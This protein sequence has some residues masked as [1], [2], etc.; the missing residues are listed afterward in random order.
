[1]WVLP[2]VLYLGYLTGFVHVDIEE[3]DP[4]S[5]PVDQAEFQSRMSAFY[6]VP[7]DTDGETRARE[8]MAKDFAF[9]KIWTKLRNEDGVI[10]RFGKPVMLSG[11]HVPVQVAQESDQKAEISDQKEK[12]WKASC[13]VEGPKLSGVL[14]VE[15]TWVN[16]EWIPV[17]L[18]LEGLQ[19]SGDIVCNVS[20]PLPNGLTRFTRLSNDY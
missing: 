4:Q 3:R 8:L 17:S 13:Y 9:M 20:A 1:M 19:K 18:H 2:A 7:K 10:Q 6:N 16:K 12:P 14:D 5:Q 15:F 11:F